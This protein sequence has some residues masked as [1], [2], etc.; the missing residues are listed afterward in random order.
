MNF[1]NSKRHKISVRES[2]PM[3]ILPKKGPLWLY[4]HTESQLDRPNNSWDIDGS[5]FQSPILWM[6]LE[7]L[8]LEC[9]SWKQSFLHDKAKMTR[10]TFYKAFAFFQISMSHEIVSGNCQDDRENSHKSHDENSAAWASTP[11]RRS[12]HE[13]IKRFQQVPGMHNGWRGT[14]SVSSEP[15]TSPDHSQCSQGQRI[16]PQGIATNGWHPEGQGEISSNFFEHLTY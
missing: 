3:E 1:G 8:S 15:T 7:F 5:I 2:I 14:R 6:F 12:V 13:M 10:T 16:Q 4:L 9:C 11:T